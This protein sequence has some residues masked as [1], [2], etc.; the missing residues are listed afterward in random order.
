MPL[1]ELCATSVVHPHCTDSEGLP[2]RVLLDTKVF[3]S[4]DGQ[5]CGLARDGVLIPDSNGHYPALPCCYDCSYALRAAVPRLP[6]WALA[7]DNLMLREPQ[8]FRSHGKRL[9]AMTFAMLALARMV[10]RKI[11]AEPYTNSHPSLK[12]KGLRS[13]TIAFPQA[14]C[15]ELIT[16]ALPAEPSVAT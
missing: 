16:Q 9:S 8:A 1:S 3:P 11:I 5:C 12:Q 2:I 6:K 15:R 13:N 4:S 7:N 10:V 14:R